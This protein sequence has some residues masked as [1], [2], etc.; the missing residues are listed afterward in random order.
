M[1]SAWWLIAAFYVGATAGFGAFMAWVAFLDRNEVN[2][3]E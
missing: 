1:I 3:E 2:R